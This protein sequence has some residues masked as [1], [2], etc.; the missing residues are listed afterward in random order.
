MAQ[1]R[2]GRRVGVIRGLAISGDLV[3]SRKVT[4]RRGF[5]VL[6]EKVVS[7]VGAEFES[8]I[9]APPK[10]TRGIDEFSAL[11]RVPRC[12]FDILRSINEAIWPH[13]FRAGFGWGEVDVGVA[14]RDAA[15]MDG[16]AFHRAAA[17]LE[18]ARR[19]RIPVGV[20]F[21]T[22]SDDSVVGTLEALADAHGVIVAG[23]TSRVA[24]IIRTRRRVLTA[25]EVGDELGV[26]A[27]AASSGIRRGNLDTLLR[28]ETAI[29]GLLARIPEVV[30][31][32]R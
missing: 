8:D 10:L 28:V 21:E 25:I 3:D 18:R 9:I 26:T 11:V 27:Q 13:R 7:N 31:A 5:Q 6:I 17:G 15:R 24:E 32:W 14:E 23:W 16:K 12:A 4:D 19:L 22:L 30:D 2:L 1:T 29:S 20:G